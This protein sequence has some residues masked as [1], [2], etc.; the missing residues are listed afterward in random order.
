MVTVFYCVL[1][2]VDLLSIR[3]WVR[4]CDSPVGLLPR[5][6]R[7]RNSRNTFLLNMC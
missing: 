6:I 3:K 5:E 7:R 2:P 4:R 1:K